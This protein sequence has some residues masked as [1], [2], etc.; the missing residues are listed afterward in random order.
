MKHQNIITDKNF[1]GI[2]II[3]IY[4]QISKEK[5][6]S[7]M[8]IFHPSGCLDLYSLISFKY[9]SSSHF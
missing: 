9:E 1:L 5:N 8:L 3:Y 2:H 7:S 6:L 4:Q